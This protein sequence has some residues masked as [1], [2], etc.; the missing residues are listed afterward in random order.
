MGKRQGWYNR[1]VRN[2][3]LADGLN[4]RK[5]DEIGLVQGTPG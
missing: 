5:A 1:A 3:M 4:R 2:E